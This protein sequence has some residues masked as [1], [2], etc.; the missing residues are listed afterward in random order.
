MQNVIKRVCSLFFQTFNNAPKTYIPFHQHYSHIVTVQF[1]LRANHIGP[2]VVVH[3][4]HQRFQAVPQR[5][6]IAK[7]LHQLGHMAEH[8]EKT[9]K[10]QHVA[11]GDGSDEGSVLWAK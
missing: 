10:H 8:N 7:R 2:A 1:L 6:Q 5:W 3:G 4:E 11:R 9:A